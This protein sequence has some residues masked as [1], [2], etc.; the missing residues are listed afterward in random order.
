MINLLFFF[1]F[2]IVSLRHK[3]IATFFYALQVASLS[4]VFVIGEY[5]ELDSFHDYFNVFFTILI[6]YIVISPWKKFKN[7]NEIVYKKQKRIKRVTNLLLIVNLIIFVSLSFISI[8]IFRFF[9]QINVLKYSGQFMDLLY[10]QF[11]LLIKGYLL[12][13]YLHT[14]SFFLII[15]HFYYLKNGNSKLAIYCFIMSLSLILFGLTFFSRWTIVNYILI[16]SLAFF[17]FK[18]SLA[19]KT[20]KNIKRLFTVLGATL[21]FLFISISISRFDKD[22]SYDNKIPKSSMVQ[23]TTVY[24][25]FDYLSQSHA[26]GMKI[27]EDYNFNTFNGQNAFSGILNLLKQ[28]GVFKEFDYSKGREK[29]MPDNY[30]RFNGLVAESVYDFGYILTFILALLYHVVV[31]KLRPIRN[32]ISLINAFLI[33]LLIQIPLFSIFYSVLASIIIPLILLIPIYLYLYVNRT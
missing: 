21:V 22:I 10:E 11:P 13:Y 16:Y 5:Y 6:L 17:M 8:Y 31:V 19:I 20:R 14:L 25:F 1:I 12:A 33:I 18:S 29:M 9:D 2:F 7:I 4:F 23:N 27:L 28:F 30:W 3:S 32:S 24:S 26:N 15:L